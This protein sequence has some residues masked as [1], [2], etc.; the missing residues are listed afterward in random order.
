MDIEKLLKAD[1]S[2]VMTAPSLVDTSQNAL[3][4]GL[5]QNDTQDAIDQNWNIEDNMAFDWRRGYRDAAGPGENRKTGWDNPFMET[6]NLAG[7]VMGGFI[8]TALFGLPYLFAEMERS[9]NIARGLDPNRWGVGRLAAEIITLGAYDHWEEETNAGMWSRRVGGAVGIMVPFGLASKG[10]T[11]AAKG[12]TSRSLTNSTKLWDTVASE[13]MRGFTRKY[14]QKEGAEQI[15]AA[16]GK[17]GGARVG[18]VVQVT[19]NAFKKGYNV[20]LKDAWKIANSKS[21]KNI[22][23]HSQVHM[24]KLSDDF[25]ENLLNIG[26]A[27]NKKQANLVSNK[28]ISEAM[29]QSQNSMHTFTTHFARSLLGSMDKAAFKTGG[30]FSKLLLGPDSEIYTSQIL[31]AMFSD[32]ILGT[33][34]NLALGTLQTISGKL[35]DLTG[36]FDNSL[37]GINPESQAAQTLNGDFGEMITNSFK[38]GM[39]MSLIGPTRF[40]K[41][42][43]TYG[44]QG[45]KR[46]VKSGV[47][48]II[49][50]LQPISKMSPDAIRRHLRLMN[51]ATGNTLHRYVPKI[52]GRKFKS[53]PDNELGPIMSQTRKEFRKHWTKFMFSETTKDLSSSAYRMTAGML[54]MNA[55]GLYQQFMENPAEFHKAFGRDGK[56]IVSNIIIGMI[57]SKQGRSFHTYSKARAANYL[58]TGQLRPWMS[59]NINEINQIR[60]G[61]ELLGTDTRF[62][63]FNNGSDVYNSVRKHARNQPFYKEVDNLV[64]DFYV[65][66]VDHVDSGLLNPRTAY[67]RFLTQD[68]KYNTNSTEYAVAMKRYDTF[69]QITNAY[70]QVAPDINMMFKKTRPK[71]IFELVE[72]VNSISDVKNAFSVRN[73]IDNSTIE[74]QHNANTTYKELRL[75]AIAEMYEAF[76]FDMADRVRNGVITVPELTNLDAVFQGPNIRDVVSIPA[77]LDA[78]KVLKDLTAQGT[79]DGWIISMGKK[80][81]PINPKAVTEFVKAV[82]RSTESILTHVNGA[83]NVS[84]G[85]FKG[86]G[87]GLLKLTDE[88]MRMA[89]RKIDQ[90]VQIRNALT[91]LSPTSTP[92]GEMFSSIK[93]SDFNRIREM[94]K[95]LDIDKNPVLDQVG[96]EGKDVEDV[97]KFW[98]NV[99]DIYRSLNPLGENRQK[100]IAIEDVAGLKMQM[101]KSLGDIFSG[102]VS[103]ENSLAILREHTFDFL[104]QSLQAREGI[105]KPVMMS[106]QHMM[107]GTRSLEKSGNL[108]ES[109]GDFVIRGPRGLAMPASESLFSRL[110]ALVPD[111]YNSIILEKGIQDWYTD[112]QGILETTGSLVRFT[113]NPKELK[114]I[115]DTMGP[116][117]IVEL[118][119]QSRKLSEEKSIENLV[120]M[121]IPAEM[122]GIKINEVIENIKQAKGEDVNFKIADSE[123][124]EQAFF[125]DLHNLYK[126]TRSFTELVQYALNTNDYQMLVNMNMKQNRLGKI[127]SELDR[128]ASID[129]REANQITAEY[130][131][132][133]GQQ[134]KNLENF[135]DKDFG[136]INSENYTKYVNEQMEQF[137]YSLDK[138]T[139]VM[140]IKITPAQ[141]ESRYG[142]DVKGVENIIQHNIREYKLNKSDR[143]FLHQAQSDLVQKV[144]ENL[145][146][147]NKESKYRDSDIEIDAL[148]QVLTQINTKEVPKLTYVDG[149]WQL[150]KTYMVDQTD[151]G[152]LALGDFLNI[153]KKMYVLDKTFQFREQG[154]L[155]K[156]RSLT[157]DQKHQFRSNIESD[158]MEI[159]DPQAVVDN[160]KGVINKAKASILQPER[161]SHISFDE[162]VDIVIPKNTAKRAILEGFSESGAVYNELLKL[163]RPN[164]PVFVD[165]I[166]KYNNPGNLSSDVIESG[167]LLARLV[168]DHPL[169][170][171]K[172]SGS[173]DKMELPETLAWLLLIIV[174]GLCG[175]WWSVTIGVNL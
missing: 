5:Y 87:D 56:D 124:Q 114:R 77:G 10:V 75:N 61:L 51:D 94:L 157:E 78:V 33:T 48:S 63:S 92:K 20:L 100:D 161:Y 153:S 115:L 84:K 109:L 67:I 17:Q 42:G 134:V 24:Q 69:E 7:N 89:S 58:E 2:S 55:P 90:H 65:D 37:E 147:L 86:G 129:P 136:Q 15:I 122:T 130:K 135:L 3:S 47:T 35:G 76:G 112:F 71:E 98:S 172:N 121:T 127:I 164:D 158:L 41:G 118:L 150:G 168:K 131:M 173:I 148:Q 22:A 171:V 49:K 82:G 95:G 174:V 8:D 119:D 27:T 11:W 105:S 28:F 43:A 79:A 88:S 59:S 169:A 108:N 29:Y 54:A 162:G 26:I 53:I 45:F 160:I 102:S 113:N 46:Q 144:K 125:G 103:G 36:Q 110:R 25:A 38:H 66:R 175:I 74:A 68:L 120:K 97:V 34:Y 104:R 170:I 123:K 52:K 39:W 60:V 14:A 141:F 137:Q 154:R 143:S 18:D 139:D 23:K 155:K 149:H 140:M 91:V 64:R 101:E 80:E 126:Q 133:L 81:V 70:D 128:F 116:D 111:K 72:S 30:K 62:M 156:F 142:L 107:N 9:A 13:S 132:E 93:E 12:M 163:Y 19:D 106:L 151:H 167:I 138:K 1:Y 31:G 32:L 40:I 165:L 16:V 99:K 166:A 50:G 85:Y 159:N 152:V 44:G 21:Y 73:L 83:D 96:K 117:K 4:S 6:A 57:F 145:K 146:T